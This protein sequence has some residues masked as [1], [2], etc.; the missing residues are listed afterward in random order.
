MTS[1]VAKLTIVYVS[2]MVISLMFVGLSNAKIDPKSV[3][4]IWLLDEGSGKTVKD[5][6]QNGHEGEVLGNTKWA[7]GKISDALEF[8]GSSDSYVSV[9]HDKSL[10]LVTWTATAWVKMQPGGWQG[11][12]V[13]S[14]KPGAADRNYGIWTWTGS[15][16]LWAQSHFPAAATAQGKTVITDGQWY[17]VAGTYDEKAVRAYV[18]GQLEKEV[19]AAGKPVTNDEPLTIGAASAGDFFTKGVIDD[20]G[21]F[22][23]ALTEV[24]IKNIMTDGLV[25]TLGLTAVEASAKLSTTWA[26]IKTQEKL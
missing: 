8:Q 1:V 13:K 16:E 17:H 23:I 26:R 3:V 24:D 21:L 20:V 14:K 7:K 12:L 10:S 25:K 4:G 18:N 9:P 6:S 15:G 11:I 2:L 19:A 5:S 22:N